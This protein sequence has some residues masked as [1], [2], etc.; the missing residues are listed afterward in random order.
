MPGSATFGHLFY[1]AGA[2]A[3]GGNDLQQGFCGGPRVGLTRRGDG[4]YDLELSYFQIDG[5]RNDKAVVP[6]DPGDCL[7]MRAPG[8]WLSPAVTPGGWVGW[9]QTNQSSTQA[10]AW[11]Y[12]TQLRNAELNVW[13]N[14]ACPLTL[15][16][17]FR[18][19]NLS[20]DLAGALSPPT[21]STEPPFWNT[22]TSNN[23]FGFQI[24]ANGKVLQRGR[25]SI[26]GLIKAGIYDNNAEQTTAVSVIAKQVSTAS[27][28]T[29]HAAFVGE[30]GLQCS[31]QVTRALSLKAG[32]QLIWLEGVAL[33]PGQIQETY[34]TTKIFDN[35]VQ[36]LGIN[37]SS[38]VFYHGATV[39]L[40]YSF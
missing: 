23:L 16:A 15:L 10:M 3:L 17:G 12:A 9:I 40:E 5:W 24:G 26:D 18:W 25:F 1:T 31:Y 8:R 39:G 29:N 22:T 14:R 34:T 35:S 19:V 36:A 37:C 32:Y 38:G 20:E 11:E 30:T 27:A 33:A 7:V 2:E 4:G 13:S 6:D 21:I 28:S